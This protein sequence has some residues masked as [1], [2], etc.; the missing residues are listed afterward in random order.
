M[1]LIDGVE[2]TSYSN[3]CLGYFFKLMQGSAAAGTAAWKQDAAGW[4]WDNGD[5]TY[6]VNQWKEISGKFYY[7]GS[8]GYMLHD[9]TTPDGYTV[10]GN[11]VWVEN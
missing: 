5:G 10:D 3:V 9:T 7:F 2:S 1:L 8:D 11:G 4:W 6:P